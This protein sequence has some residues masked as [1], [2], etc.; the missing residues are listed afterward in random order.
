MVGLLFGRS[1]R[2]SIFSYIPLIRW[3]GPLV[4]VAGILV[5]SFFAL[6]G[7]ID[8]SKFDTWSEQADDSAQLAST[9]T[10]G[11]QH[12]SSTVPRSPMTI[13]VATFHIQMFG[14]KKSQTRS[15]PQ[16]PGV[17]VMGTISHLIRQFDLVAIQ[18]VRSNDVLP[19]QRIL[20]LVNELG[21]SYTATVSQPIGR[22][23]DTECYAFVWDMQR[24]RIQGQPYVV[25]DTADRM[26]RE[27][28]VASFMTVTDPSDTREPFRFTVINAH[29]DSDSMST[30]ATASEVNVLD[31][32]FVRVRDYEYGQ[33]GEEDCI[34]MGDLNAGLDD[35]QE[36]AMIPNVVSVA[37]DIKSDVFRRKTLDHI[38]LDRTMTTEFTG[39]TGVI[40]F[41]QDLR[42]TET[43][44]RT[45]SD[46][47]PVWAEF[48]IYESPRYQA[49]ASIPQ[50][51]R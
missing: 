11:P 42:L 13:R 29:R 45:I 26:R 2:R 37:G 41:C 47:L 36:L 33:T 4:S 38:L 35:L 18:G 23:G 17:D 22:A 31:D 44:A 30:P 7:R 39:Q 16:V 51:V 32:V 15:I 8:L 19:V 25:Q 21:G 43:Q 40:D 6:T 48:S 50:S 34:L 27:P 46:H 5:A 28:M 3:I 10:E 1:R 24:L 49:N 9:Q 14:D 20:D 12:E